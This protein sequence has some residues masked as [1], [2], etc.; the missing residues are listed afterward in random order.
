MT[1]C[2]SDP[3]CVDTQL[4]RLVRRI[5]D[6]QASAAEIEQAR[7]Q[8]GLS[9]IEALIVAE[10]LREQTATTFIGDILHPYCGC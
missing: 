9:P 8:A 6:G 5:A 2:I 7:K 3:N 10:F 1:T 4:Q